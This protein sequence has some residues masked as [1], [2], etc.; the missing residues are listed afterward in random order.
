MFSS[1]GPVIRVLRSVVSISDLVTHD[2]KLLYLFVEISSWIKKSHLFSNI[3][4]ID[5]SKSLRNT[6]V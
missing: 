5:L 1:P 3:C 6:I 4:E 2:Y